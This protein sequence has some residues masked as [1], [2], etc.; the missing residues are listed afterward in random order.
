MTTTELG[1]D[2]LRV[3]AQL[4]RWATRHATFEVPAAQARLLALLDEFGPTRISTLAAADNSSQPTTTIQVHRLEAAGWV[5]RAGE[6]DDARASRVSLTEDG[7]RALAEVRAARTAVFRPVL[8]QLV[9]SDPDALHRV[10]D[11]V[12]VIDELLD[13]AARCP[14]DQDAASGVPL[15]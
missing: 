11:A 10:R 8:A 12:A 14:L 1:A 15:S 3:V 4:N 13:I 2:L 7:V 5:Q 9:A 6:P